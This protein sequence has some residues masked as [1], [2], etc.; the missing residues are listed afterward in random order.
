MA[1]RL[2]L[3]LLLLAA[4][5]SAQEMKRYVFAIVPGAKPDISLTAE[6][7]EMDARV[8]KNMIPVQDVSG[9]LSIFNNRFVVSA[10]AGFVQP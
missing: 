9:R 1:L 8:V 7:A 6:F 10:D 3:A 2:L 4:A 5:G